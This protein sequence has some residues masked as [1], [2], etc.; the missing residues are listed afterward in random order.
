[1]HITTNRVI[2]FDHSTLPYFRIFLTGCFEF[3]QVNLCKV[4]AAVIP[5]QMPLSLSCRSFVTYHKIC[6]ILYIQVEKVLAETVF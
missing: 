1:M 4:F 5:I 3:N 2:Y 6:S